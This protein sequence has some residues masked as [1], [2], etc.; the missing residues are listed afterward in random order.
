M[1]GLRFSAILTPVP[2]TIL[3][4]RHSLARARRN[5]RRR[6]L[7]AFETPTYAAAND[8]DTPPVGYK[9][10][11][12]SAREA[13]TSQ[14]R[15][16]A[17]ARRGEQS[18]T[19]LR[20]SHAASSQSPMMTFRQRHFQVTTADLLTLKLRHAARHQLLR[21][22]LTPLDGEKIEASFE[23]YRRFRR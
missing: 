15:T 1:A 19:R 23:L 18:S 5:A 4:S 16:A 8:D 7:A 2:I 13:V 17:R 22:E 20:A 12:Y 11:D 10:L 3:K 14:K 9:Q 6:A 21:E